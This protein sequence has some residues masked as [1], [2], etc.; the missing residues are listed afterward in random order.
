MAS[1]VNLREVVNPTVAEAARAL[2]ASR[3]R[4]AQLRLAEDLVAC[5]VLEVEAWRILQKITDADVED[6]AAADASELLVVWNHFGRFW[7]LGMDGPSQHTIT[8][9]ESARQSS[10]EG[11]LS[12]AAEP[13]PAEVPLVTRE[14]E[15]AQREKNKRLD[16]MAPARR[17]NPLDEIIDF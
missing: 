12:S 2:H 9:V 11:E 16:M 3:R 15:D 10:T 14:V 4:H 5:K 7:E 8:A 13:D 6:A 1:T 17:S